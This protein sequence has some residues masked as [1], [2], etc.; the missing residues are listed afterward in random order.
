MDYQHAFQPA[1]EVSEV[2]WR[3]LD[4]YS[5]LTSPQP[6]TFPPEETDTSDFS[7][8][9]SHFWRRCKLPVGRLLLFILA[10][11]VLHEV[12]INGSS[13]LLRVVIVARQTLQGKLHRRESGLSSSDCTSEG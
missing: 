2:R 7:H 5:D 4:Q 3:K 9:F 8:C 11:D 13:P 6:I 1:S 10:P 12:D